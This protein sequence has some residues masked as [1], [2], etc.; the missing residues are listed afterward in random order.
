VLRA[1]VVLEE[2]PKRSV[3]LLPNAEAVR[4]APGPSRSAK[5]RRFDHHSSSWPR[6]ARA[7]ATSDA[8]YLSLDLRLV[9]ATAASTRGVIFGPRLSKPS[10]RSTSATASSSV[11]NRLD[12][13]TH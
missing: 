5:Q 2:E 10:W 4:G 13:L 3:A 12:E 7:K 1:A 8:T 11:G 6:P 9:L